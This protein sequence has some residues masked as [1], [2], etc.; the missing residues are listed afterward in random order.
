MVDL[1]KELPLLFKTGK[2]IYGYK[3][4]VSA[5]YHSKILGVIVASKVPK[6]IKDK[7]IYYCK[8]AG[9]PYYIFEGSSVELGK[10]CGKN[11][12]ISSIAILNPGES[13]IMELFQK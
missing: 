12:V 13:S 11:F 5:L 10:L 7:V 9:V 4:V 6:Q 2:V 8:L 3:E 1:T